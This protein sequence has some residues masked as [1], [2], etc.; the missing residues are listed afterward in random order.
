MDVPTTAD[1]QRAVEVLQ[2]VNGGPGVSLLGG[3]RMG[4]GGGSSV[5]VSG[6]SLSPSP[7]FSWVLS[8]SASSTAPLRTGEKRSICGRGFT[9][10]DPKRAPGQ[11][12]GSGRTLRVTLLATTRRSRRALQR[13]GRRSVE[14]FPF[15]P[16]IDRKKP[17]DWRG[18]HRAGRRCLDRQAR[19]TRALTRA[20]D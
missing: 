3:S 17:L 8:C 7:G 10:S 6:A 4:T 18:R 16:A 1:Q 15:P 20:L 11:A 13:F 14:P 5:G 2:T 9:S 12:A 19:F